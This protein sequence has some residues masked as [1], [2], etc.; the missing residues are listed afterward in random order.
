MDTRLS[1]CLGWTEVIKVFLA[2]LLRKTGNLEFF[3]QAIC[4]LQTEY[5]DFNGRKILYGLQ[6]EKQLHRIFGM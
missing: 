4:C 5:E 1:F 3:P 6:F 2:G